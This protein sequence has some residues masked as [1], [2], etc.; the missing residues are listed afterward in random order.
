[1]GIIINYWGGGLKQCKF[2]PYIKKENTHKFVDIEA[3]YY[4]PYKTQ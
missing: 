3:L 2:S 1:M 4:L